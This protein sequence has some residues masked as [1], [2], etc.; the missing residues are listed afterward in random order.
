MHLS[1]PSD[2]VLRTRRKSRRKNKLIQMQYKPRA[3]KSKEANSE[4]VILLFFFQREGNSCGTEWQSCGRLT[5]R[6]DTHR[7]GSL[8]SGPWWTFKLSAPAISNLLLC[9]IW[10]KAKYRSVQEVKGYF[11]CIFSKHETLSAQGNITQSALP[12]PP[13]SWFGFKTSALRVATPFFPCRRPPAWDGESL[14]S[15]GQK[16][17]PCKIDLNTKDRA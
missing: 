5:Q 15:R 8:I 12:V 4:F 1:L 17:N 9:C 6:C 14:I 10:G 16:T 2:W 13:S 7:S 11:L 3:G